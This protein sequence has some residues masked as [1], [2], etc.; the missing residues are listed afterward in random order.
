[1]NIVSEMKT[2]DSGPEATLD[3]DL[4]LLVLPQN[5]FLKRD[6]KDSNNM[7][8]T[9]N[10]Q[11][12]KAYKVQISF[13]NPC[14][15]PNIKLL[16]YYEQPTFLESIKEAWAPSHNIADLISDIVSQVENFH[17]DQTLLDCPPIKNM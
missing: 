5:T 12:E 2:H 4:E 16:K 10:F 7:V 11:A 8:L 17:L 1:M 13:M 9:V 6:D 15:A 14:Q 3:K